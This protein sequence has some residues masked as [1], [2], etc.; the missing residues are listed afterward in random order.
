MLFL[1]LVV[2]G[3]WR[4]CNTR[5]PVLPFGDCG[6]L[7]THFFHHAAASV[8]YQQASGF[9]WSKPHQ[10]TESTD[11]ASTARIAS[12]PNGAGAA[13]GQTEQQP[14]T[15][16]MLGPL[17][18]T[19]LDLLSAAALTRG[20]G[21]GGAADGAG[22]RPSIFQDVLDQVWLAGGDPPVRARRCLHWMVMGGVVVEWLAGKCARPPLPTWIDVTRRYGGLGSVPWVDAQGCLLFVCVTPDPDAA[23]R[24]RPPHCSSSS[25]S[26]MCPPPP[27]FPTEL[28]PR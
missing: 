9:V 19:S 18:Q 8:I 1:R 13:A 28:S 2:P 17:R 21:N 6:Y 15:K 12:A 7:I 10:P 27:P 22:M 5:P 25:R 3:S 14:C 16:S 4:W 20:A 11:S 26:Y 24:T 23:C